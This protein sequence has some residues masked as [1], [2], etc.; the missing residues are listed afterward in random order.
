MYHWPWH[1]IKAG[2]RSIYLKQQHKSGTFDAKSYC[3]TDP[4]SSVRTRYSTRIVERHGLTVSEGRGLSVLRKRKISFSRAI[5]H[6]IVLRHEK[7]STHTPALTG[8]WHE[9]MLSP[10]ELKVPLNVNNTQYSTAGEMVGEIPPMW[11]VYYIGPWHVPRV[12]N[13]MR[14]DLVD[15]YKRG[16]DRE[17]DSIGR[18]RIWPMTIYLE[19]K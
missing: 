11:V 7:M 12:C 16:G 14:R 3:I 2:G 19:S 1:A 4:C 18:D 10:P 8:L 9:G 13:M 17:Y 15:M 6:S 5:L